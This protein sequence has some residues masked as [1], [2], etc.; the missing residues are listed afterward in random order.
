ML[1]VVDPNDAA[2]LTFLCPKLD[3]VSFSPCAPVCVCFKI[4]PVLGNLFGH[5]LRLSLAARRFKCTFSGLKKG[6]CW[7]SSPKSCRKWAPSPHRLPW[8][9][10]CLWLPPS[11]CLPVSAGPN[12]ARNAA[13][14]AETW[15]EWLPAP[16]TRA[17]LWIGLF[18]KNPVHFSVARGVYKVVIEM[19]EVGTRCMFT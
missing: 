9:F 12:L 1:F 6:C 2:K 14:H 13:F 17:A 16:T 18:R 15:P 5:G 8:T 3:T 10:L 19:T 11:L 4:P 7:L